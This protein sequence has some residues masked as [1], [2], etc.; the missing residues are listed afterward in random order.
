MPPP[1]ENDFSALKKARPGG[2]ATR[3]RRRP[4][5]GKRHEREVGAREHEGVAFPSGRGT[6]T[7]RT[8]TLGRGLLISSSR[9]N[10]WSVMMWTPV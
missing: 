3:V 5:E 9:M 6:T 8:L 1:W 7:C 10:P 4:R 2:T